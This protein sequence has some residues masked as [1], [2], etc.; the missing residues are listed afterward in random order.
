MNRKFLGFT[1]SRFG[2]KLKVADKA[3]EALKNRVRELTRRTRGTREKQKGGGDELFSTQDLCCDV[4]RLPH[5]WMG[6]ESLDSEY[7]LR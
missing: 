6:L 1:V 5:D 2:V 3:I 4:A 7:Q